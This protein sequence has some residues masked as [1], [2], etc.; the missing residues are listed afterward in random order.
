MKNVEIGQKAPQSKKQILG[1]R[2]LLLAPKNT[3]KWFQ[4]DCFENF[5]ERI[6]SILNLKDFD[7]VTPIPFSNLRA[8]DCCNCSQ[9]N[10]D[11][12]SKKKAIRISKIIIKHSTKFVDKN[13]TPS[14]TILLWSNFPEDTVAPWPN[15]FESLIRSVATTGWGLGLVGKKVN[16][17][18]VL[19]VEK[20]T[21]LLRCHFCVESDCHPC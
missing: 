8:S 17:F 15:F 12:N 4:D 19:L 21:S 1:W 2:P 9:L 7:N 11:L 18:T 10:C 14:E 16:N 6:E 5:I 20:T 3:A 13:S